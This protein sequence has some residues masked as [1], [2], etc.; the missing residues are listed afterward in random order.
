VEEDY[1]IKHYL[2]PSASGLDK[3]FPLPLP[4]IQ[5]LKKSGTFI[6]Q[7][8]LDKTVSTNIIAKHVSNPT[9]V[10]CVEV[11]KNTEDEVTGRFIRLVGTL[12]LVK[13]GY[14]FLFL[15]AAVS[16]ISFTTGQTEGLTTRVA[17]HLPQADNSMRNIFFN[18]LHAQA[19]SAGLT[20]TTR[21]IESMPDFWGPLLSVQ[22]EG[23]ALDVIRILRDGAWKSYERYCSQTTDN[24]DFDYIPVQHQMI[25]KTSQAEH[26]FFKKMGLAVAAEAQ[27]A[28]FSVLAA[29]L[30]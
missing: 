24:P 12:S 4:D 13:K 27:A 23:I 29:N 18:T 17:I 14:P 1:F 3:G 11:Y 2:K 21:V 9:G 20:S 30:C 22:N 7:G 8:S 16:N 10:R 15:D 6:V 19:E 5:G 28:F 25:L 26:H